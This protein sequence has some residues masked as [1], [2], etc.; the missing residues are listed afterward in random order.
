VYKI[1][2][3]GVT[4]ENTSDWNQQQQQQQQQQKTL[5]ET[6]VCQAIENEYW[7]PQCNEKYI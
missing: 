3:V 2:Y 1:D 5:V 6:K 4:L 7:S